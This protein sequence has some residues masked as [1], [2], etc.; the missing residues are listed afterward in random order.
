MAAIVQAIATV[1]LFLLTGVLAW[2]TWLLA[3]ESREAR[4]DANR[5]R[6]SAKFQQDP[7]YGSF[8]RLVLKNLGRGPALNLRFSLN[9]NEADF[10]KHKVRLLRNTSAPINF[11]SHEEAETYHFG[12]AT[13]LFKDP[14]MESFTVQLE[15]EDLDG[16]HYDHSVNLNVKE[17]QKLVRVSSSVARK[18]LTA[19]EGIDTS[20]KTLV[21]RFSD[22]KKNEDAKPRGLLGLP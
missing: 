15:Y 11:L 3:R 22:E 18:Q 2:A 7:D 10:E 12:T 13:N 1:C 21:D 8:I 19:L 14:P 20:V 6:V 9:G 5:P 16:K 4:A 17:F